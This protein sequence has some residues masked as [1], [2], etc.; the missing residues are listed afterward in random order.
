MSLFIE[1]CKVLNA[2]SVIFNTTKKLGKKTYTDD[3]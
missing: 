1:V 2:L 3:T